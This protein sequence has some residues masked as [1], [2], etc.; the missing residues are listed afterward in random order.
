LKVDAA[1][2]PFVRAHVW[3]SPGRRRPDGAL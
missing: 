2:R 3:P 1:A